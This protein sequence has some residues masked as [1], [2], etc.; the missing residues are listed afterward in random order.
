[1]QF[2]V[3]GW[4]HGLARPPLRTA[5]VL[6]SRTSPAPPRAGERRG[7]EDCLAGAWKVRKRG[8]AGR[9]LT[10]AAPQGSLPAMSGADPELDH[11]KELLAD[12]SHERKGMNV[13]E[14][15]GCVAASSY[16]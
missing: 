15:D 1:M 10:G 13:V 6:A 4:P 14:P 2:A 9:V 16:K 5:R 12:M 8:H 7:L 3:S 11:L